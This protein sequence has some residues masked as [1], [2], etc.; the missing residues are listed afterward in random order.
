MNK[1]DNYIDLSDIKENELDKTAS[2]T[3]LMS[4]SERKQR[5]KEKQN[6]QTQNNNETI[7]KLLNN[8]NDKN[9]IT[10]NNNFSINSENI[11]DNFHKIQQDLNII[12]ESNQEEFDDIDNIINKKRKYP[13]GNLIVTAFLNI[14]SIIYFIYSVYY[15]DILNRNKFLIINSIIILSMAFIFCLSLISNK[16]ICKIFC[17]LNYIVITGYIAFNVLLTLGYLK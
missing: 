7:S 14:I 9:K 17:I 11:V 15:T 3:D 6:E 1:Q 8:L 16:K 2:F 10:E 12:N 13:V 5:E 4:R